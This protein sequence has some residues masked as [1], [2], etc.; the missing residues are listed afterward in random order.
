MRAQIRRIHAA[1]YRPSRARKHGFVKG[2]ITGSP[3]G[4]FGLASRCTH[5]PGPNLWYAQGVLPKND[6]EARVLKTWITWE[7][8]DCA[9][10][11]DLY[12]GLLNRCILVECGS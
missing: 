3:R 11:R 5:Y 6:G 12:S 2:I 7:S 8:L 9:G 4:G 10:K 1:N